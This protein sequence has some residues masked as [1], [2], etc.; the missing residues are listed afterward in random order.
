MHEVVEQEGEHCFWRRLLERRQRRGMQQRQGLVS[1]TGVEV[2]A[3]GN[4]IAPEA[5]RIGIARIQCQPCE[6]RK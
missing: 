5:C 3:C 2:L 1:D 4:E 6:V